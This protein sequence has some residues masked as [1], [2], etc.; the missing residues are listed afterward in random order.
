MVEINGYQ[1]V[2]ISCTPQ[3]NQKKFIESIQSRAMKKIEKLLEQGLDPNFIAED[4]SK[5]AFAHMSLCPSRT[6]SLLYLMCLSSHAP[7]ADTPLGVCCGRDSH[8]ECILPLMSLGAH[9]DFRGKDGLTPVHRAAIGGNTQAL[10]VSI[11]GVEI[12]TLSS[13]ASPVSTVQMLLSLGASPNCRDGKGLT[14]LY[15]ASI[16]GDDVSVCDTLLRYRSDMGI[17][18]YGGWTELHQV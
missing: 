5:G 7:L 1:C 15:H 2:R 8:M 4:G 10:K 3:V 9:T 12:L 11:S 13:H 17:R 18:D 6:T 16:M 14:P